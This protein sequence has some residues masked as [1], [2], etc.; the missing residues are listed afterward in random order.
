MSA[1]NSYNSL[2]KVDNTINKSLEK[3]STGLRINRAGDDAAGLAI[4]E[5]MRGQVN[6]LNM[7]TR[8]SQDGISMIQTAEGALN[9]TH[10]IL[11]RM[12]ELAVQSS[13]GTNTAEDREALQSEISELKSEID[14]I[15]NTTEF[16]TQKL[17]DGTQAG[18][19]GA[20]GTE[21]ISGAN[22]FKATK[23]KLVGVDSATDLTAANAFDYTKTDALLIE[24]KKV[25]IQW[26]KYLTDD[27]KAKLEKD[28]NGTI[29]QAMGDDVAAVFEKAINAAIADSGTGVANVQ[30]T[31]NAT[32]GLTIESTR[33]GSESRVELYVGDGA[34]LT[35]K[36][37]DGVTDAAGSTSVLDNLFGNATEMAVNAVATSGQYQLTEDFNGGE[38]YRVVINGHAMQ[39]TNGGN[40]ATGASITDVA[41]NMQVDINSVIADYNSNAGYTSEEDKIKDV[42]VKATTDGRIVITSPSGAVSLEELTKGSTSLEAIGMDDASREGG[43]TGSM[44]FQIGANKGQTMSFSIKDM[45][46]SAL[47][48]GGIDVST[49]T[50]AQNAITALD[51]AISTVSSQRAK[52]GA[53][54]NRLEHTINNLTTSSENLQSAES[55]VR[56]VDMSLEMVA[57]S[58]NKIISQAANS[59]L[60]QA[61]QNPQNVLSLLR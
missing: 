45:R 51:K 17:L 39:V 57:Y 22:V 23:G 21:G 34:T 13:N 1:V 35:A 50:G 32:A 19:N 49:S 9:E 33:K 41:S 26:S 55:R 4:S 47:G 14:R 59:M 48:I 10:S 28:W 37:S 2:N 18:V 24:G 61:N 30:V 16:N 11:Q 54:Q 3:L 8:N 36:L 29:T 42:E 43:A 31:S 38:D 52:L 15:G 46:S 12:R 6:G 56:D 7:A 40:G 25:D 53:V 27:D 58:K 60:A 5:K 20:E 44:T